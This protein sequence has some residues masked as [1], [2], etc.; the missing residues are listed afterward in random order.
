MGQTAENVAELLGISREDQDAF[1]LR[2]Q[3]KA[4][5]ARAGGSVRPRDPAGRGPR[6]PRGRAT[7]VV[8]QDEFIQPDTTPELLAK[9][10]PA[11]RTDG[12]GSVTAGNASG[13][14]DGACALLVASEAGLKAAGRCRSPGSS[15]APW[16]AS[17]RG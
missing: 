4:A 9:L 3:Q 8:D 15:R 17:S 10:K 14:N 2:S 6:R 1:A 12:K 5:A 11:F 16:R 13:L 7:D